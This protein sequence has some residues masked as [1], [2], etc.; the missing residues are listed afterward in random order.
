MCDQIIVWK[1]IL[2]ENIY[3]LLLKA[4]QASE[5]GRKSAQ[6]VAE[7]AYVNIEIDVAGSTMITD[8]Y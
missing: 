5:L 4:Q 3:K 8:V 2:F 7:L 1:N 6:V